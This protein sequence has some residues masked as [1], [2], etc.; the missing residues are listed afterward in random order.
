MCNRVFSGLILVMLCASAAAS[1]YSFPT[2]KTSGTIHLND[3]GSIDSRSVTAAD[4]V[5]GA[6]IKLLPV[7]NIFLANIASPGTD[8]TVNA[9]VVNVTDL[10][11]WQIKLTWDPNLLSFVNITLPSDNV[12]AGSGKSLIVPPPG[13]YADG[14]MWGAT[15]INDPYWTFNGTGTLCRIALKILDPPSFPAVTNLTLA[16][17]GF[18][19]FL[20]DGTAF[21]DIAFNAQDGIYR[22]IETVPTPTGVN[23]TVSPALDVGLVFENVTSAGFT[24]AYETQLGPQLP[25]NLTLVGQYYDVATNAGFSGNLTISVTYDDSNLTQAQENSLQLL[26]WQPQACDVTGLTVGTPDGIV[27]MRDIGY[28]C[29]KF[30]TT[31]S[32]QNWDPRCDV[33]GPT[34]GV[35]DG[36][37]N[38]RDIGEVA[39]NFMKTSHWSN[40]TTY[41]DTSSNVIY[42]EASHL[43]MF[44]VTR[45]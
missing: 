26:Q 8:F 10:Q 24:G 16:E 15:Y 37:V 7:E 5:A 11:N 4:V 3:D 30:V 43:S 1:S 35:P 22:Y 14:V 23:V 13:V 39:R 29:S 27:N 2:V 9:M 12:F 19:T 40:I 6:T 34:P 28:F 41:V 45:W 20:L 25:V 18:N 36:I 44:G 21:R 17:L 31:P 33:T 38:M 42:G 32:S